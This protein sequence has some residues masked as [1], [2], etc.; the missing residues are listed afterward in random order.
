MI[1][2]VD[3]GVCKYKL[4]LKQSGVVLAVCKNGWMPYDLD[5]E[6]EFN[7]KDLGILVGFMNAVL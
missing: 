2:L 1:Y 7:A 3:L 4:T 6:L 5:T